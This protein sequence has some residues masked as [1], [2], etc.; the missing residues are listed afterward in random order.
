MVI[1]AIGNGGNLI[2]IGSADTVIVDVKLPDIEVKKEEL[3]QSFEQQ[4]SMSLGYIDLNEKPLSQPRYK[5]PMVRKIT[6]KPMPVFK[7]V[8]RNARSRL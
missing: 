7:K 2:T 8:V 3:L 5:H 1:V 4:M 6:P